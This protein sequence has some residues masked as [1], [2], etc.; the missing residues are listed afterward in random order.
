MAVYYV[1]SWSMGQAKPRWRKRHDE[2]GLHK[3]PEAICILEQ[4]FSWSCFPPRTDREIVLLH[5]YVVHAAYDLAGK[6]PPILCG[7]MD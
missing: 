7:T 2:R 4:S 5:T 6:A 3:T 1:P